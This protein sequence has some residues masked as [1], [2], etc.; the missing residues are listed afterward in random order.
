MAYSVGDKV[1]HSLPLNL[2]SNPNH[3]PSRPERV[4]VPA[5]VINDEI[6]TEDRISRSTGNP[7]KVRLVETIQLRTRIDGVTTWLQQGWEPETF[8]YPRFNTTEEPQAAAVEG[9]D[10]IGGVV[11]TILDLQALRSIQPGPETRMPTLS[12]A[13]A[14]QTA[15]AQAAM[16]APAAA[17][18]LTGLSFPNDIDEAATAALLASGN[19]AK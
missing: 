17:S 13:V 18:V 6:R 19:E 10:H 8:T 15:A 12:A 9:L 1:K 5:I 3:D 4:V 14:A 2:K 7:F 11:P 16:P